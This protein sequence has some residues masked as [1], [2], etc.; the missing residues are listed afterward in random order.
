MMGNFRLEWMKNR[1]K[2]YR[3]NIRNAQMY[4]IM[5]NLSYIGRDR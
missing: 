2:R 4:E 1:I 3:Q 5:G